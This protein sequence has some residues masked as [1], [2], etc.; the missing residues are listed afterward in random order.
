MRNLK[1][2]DPLFLFGLSFLFVLVA[3]FF[4]QFVVIPVT[5]WH[6]GSGLLATGDYAYFH[7][8]AVE[9]ASQ[10]Q[11]FGWAAWEPRFEGQ[12]PAGVAA[13]LYAVTNIEHPV[14]LLPVNAFLFS[15][16]VVLLY[17]IFVDLGMRHRQALVAV[18]PFFVFPSAAMVWGQIHKDIYS[19][20]GVVFILSFWLRTM[21]FYFCM[22]RALSKKLHVWDFFA[23]FLGVA[24]IYY[25]R[26]YFVDVV[27]VACIFTLLTVFIYIA[28]YLGVKIFDKDVIA[29]QVRR[30]FHGIL[31]CGVGIF[32]QFALM[33]SLEI[34]FA[35]ESFSAGAG[36]GSDLES[37]RTVV[38]PTWSVSSVLPSY[39]D[40][41]LAGLACA[42]NGFVNSAPYAGS[43]IDTDV[44][45]GS[46]GD[47]VSYLPR[48]LQISFFAPFPD[49]WFSEASESLGRAMRSVAAFE[50]MFLYFVFPGILFA[51][52]DHRTRVAT[53]VA[54]SLSVSLA[55][56]YTLAVA[57]VGT[58]YRMRYPSMLLWAVF[59]LA[60][61]MRFLQ[62]LRRGAA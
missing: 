58:L 61:W 57:N 2:G 48:A 19:F 14:I 52:V 47:I 23:L 51:L 15:L 62:S 31:M 25:V 17:R 45:F 50:M 32:I 40:D 49:M 11:D 26:P 18:L 37:G 16:T 7:S 36:V 1:F 20:L 12:A 3:G 43:N 28:L 22:S 5:P 55:L 53:L 4:L 34:V 29:L 9:N 41:R 33:Q 24:L 10:I 56:V 39:V 30:A 59:G 38:C 42:R 6:A 60:G 54:V 35:P 21:T 8:L 46:V 44:K 27:F 13:A